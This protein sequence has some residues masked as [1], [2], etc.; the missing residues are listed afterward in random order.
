[1]GHYRADMYDS[2]EAWKNRYKLSKS[3]P[4]EETAFRKLLLRIMSKKR[5]KVKKPKVPNTRST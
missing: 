4:E 5:K 1:M 3:T 2:E